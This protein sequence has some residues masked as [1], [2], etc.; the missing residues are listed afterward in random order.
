MSIGTLSRKLYLYPALF[1]LGI[2]VCTADV[3]AGTCPARTIAIVG[4]S[5][6]AGTG[7]SDYAHAWAGLYTA[8][9][10]SL[11]PSNQ[12]IN[13][14]VGGYTTFHELPTG[15]INPRNRPAVDTAH[16]ITAALA[17][18]PDAVIINLPSNDAASGFSEVETETNYLKMVA[19]CQASN[20][21]VW[22]ATTQP[23]NLSSAG[24]S[25]LMDVRAWTISTFPTH[26]LDFW[27]T[28][29]NADGH[30]NAAYGAGN[31]IHLNNAGHRILCSR[32]VASRLYELVSAPRT[33]AAPMKP[34]TGDP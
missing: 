25:N 26:Y 15:T 3:A 5:T 27:T 16:N 30:I 8:C 17:A 10:I 29:A 31:G 28:V 19:A 7:A 20:V 34:A 2:H 24:R 6:A 23:R 4:S 33:V 1:L 14:A 18:H 22:I 32:V 13:L 9:L 21:P 12:V 11:N